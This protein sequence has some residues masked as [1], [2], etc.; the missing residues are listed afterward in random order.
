MNVLVQADVKKLL[1]GIC[2][3]RYTP[4]S[5][6]LFSL[7]ETSAMYNKTRIPLHEN[8]DLL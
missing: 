2:E 1:R 3:I 6:T 5:E 7:H 4:C 8:G